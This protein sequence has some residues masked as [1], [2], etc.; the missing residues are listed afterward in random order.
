MISDSVERYSKVLK[1]LVSHVW[2][3]KHDV[4]VDMKRLETKVDFLSEA[5]A[6]KKR[7]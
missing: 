3:M 4:M 2:D 5:V 6:G 1:D 7:N